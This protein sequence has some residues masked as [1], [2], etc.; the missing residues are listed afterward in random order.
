MKSVLRGM[1]STADY[2]NGLNDNEGDT[3]T[4]RPSAT[5]VLAIDSDDRYKNYLVR[6]TNPTYPF[7]INIQ[8]NENILNG[9]F[10]RLALTEFRLNWTL[11]NISQVW[12]NSTIELAYCLTADIGTSPP[13]ATLIVVP[14]G[15]YGAEELANQLQKEIQAQTGLA[16]L[17]VTKNSDD[18]II[19]FIAPPTYSFFLSSQETN[20][21]ELCDVLNVPVFPVPV[22]GIAPSGNYSVVVNSGVPNLRPMDFFDL[23]CSELSY[24]Q[25]L[26]DTTSAPIYRDMIARIYLDDSVPSSSLVTTNYFTNTATTTTITGYPTGTIDDEVTFTVGTT[27]NF[28]VGSPATISGFTNGVNWNGDVEII[29]ITGTAGGTIRVL[30]N[31]TPG[32]IPT[33]GTGSISAKGITQQS[34]PITTWDDRVNGVTPFVIYRQFPYPKQIRWNKAMPIGNLNFEMYDDQGRNIQDLWNRVYSPTSPIGLSYANS[35]VWNA[36]IL[37]SED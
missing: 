18:D 35:F 20:E 14:D 10:R 13:T 28:T 36:T 6:R 33:T 12:G 19:S 31:D 9:F 4:I 17:V 11:P 24:N 27:T 21:R 23:V 22:T 30:Y 3:V 15:F 29:A 37:V 26:K 25:D 2:V 5:A 8:K 34:T 32:T 1:K 16:F 7:N